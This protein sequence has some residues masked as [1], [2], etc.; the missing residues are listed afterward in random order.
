MVLTGRW[1]PRFRT[2]RNC[3]FRSVGPAFRLRPGA[4]S[5]PAVPRSGAGSV[6]SWASHPSLPDRAP[7]PCVDERSRIR[8][9]HRMQP[10][11]PLLP[12]ISERHPHDRSCNGAIPLFVATG[13][14]IEECRGCCRAK[15]FPDFPREV[16]ARVPDRNA[17]VRAW[18]ARRP[19]RHVRFTP[20]LPPDR[21]G[22]APVHRN[23]AR[24][25]IHTSARQSDADIRTLIEWRNQD[26]KPFKRAKSADGIPNAVKCIRHP[27]NRKYDINFSFI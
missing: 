9:P 6:T 12:D 1:L 13:L 10:V 11:P 8:P 20:P 25:G 5:L 17:A 27:V 18:L 3:L 2:R 4:S 26:P 7:T 15:G 21:S 24:T 14:A 16:D 22:R 19:H 23:G